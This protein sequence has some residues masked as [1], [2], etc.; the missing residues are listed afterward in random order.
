MVSIVEP[1]QST[2]HRQW[3]S[4]RFSERLCILSSKLRSVYFLIFQTIHNIQHP[5]VFSHFW[6]PFILQLNKP[7]SS[8]TKWFF[9]NL[10]RAFYACVIDAW[11][12]GGHGWS[13]RKDYWIYQRLI[14]RVLVCFNRPPCLLHFP[15]TLPRHINLFD[16]QHEITVNVRQDAAD[17]ARG[18]RLHRYTFV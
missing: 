7:L 16:P 12:S 6:R 10:L 8:S 11:W 14:G 17:K 3:T 5:T 1:L 18:W 13:G 15:R 4:A 2:D 9:L